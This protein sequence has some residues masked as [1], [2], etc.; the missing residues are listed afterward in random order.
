[1]I[2]HLRLTAA[3]QALGLLHPICAI[4]AQ[5]I[6]AVSSTDT[7]TIH[8]QIHVDQGKPCGGLCRDARL[9]PC[10]IHERPRSR[11]HR[12]QRQRKYVRK[13]LWQHHGEDVRQHGRSQS[14]CHVGRSTCQRGPG[15][16]W[17]PRDL[18]GNCWN[19]LWQHRRC[20]GPS[21]GHRHVIIE[22]DRCDTWLW[23]YG[24]R[25]WHGNRHG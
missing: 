18:I 6:D 4:T 23:R 9:R 13:D 1:M 14:P 24:Y 20:R 11:E 7:E 3:E 8:D 17:G 21:D 2:Q 10:P 25:S 22:H 19:H 16:P 15:Q 12:G 5:G